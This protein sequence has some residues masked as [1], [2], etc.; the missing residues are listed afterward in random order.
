MTTHDLVLGGCR[1]EPLAA[2]LKALG[3]L[4]AVAEQ[5]DPDA[6]G[7]W[8][9][10]HFVLRSSL[11]RTALVEMFSTRWRP[12]PVV[13]PWNGGSGFYPKDN[14]EA[15][16]K[17]AASTDPRLA[18]YR[19][20]IAVAARE[21]ARNA[22]SERPVDDAKVRLLETMRSTLPDEGVSWVDAAVVVGDDRLLFPPL[23]G[24][25]GN[26]GRLDF[27]NNFMQRVV[28]VLLGGPDRIEATL[29]DDPIALKFQGAMGQFL[30]SASERTN[31]WDFVLLIEGALLFA[32]AATKKL[33]SAERGTMA[34]P[35]HARAALGAAT[36]SEKD[37]SGSR[38]ELWLPLW[39]R[40]ASLRELRA[41]L[42]E[43]RAKVGTRERGADATRGARDGLDFARAVAQ[44]G[45]DRGITAFSR[46][47]FHVRNG[48]AYY[49]TPLGRFET[50][51]VPE[52][53][54]FDALDPWIER[55]RRAARQ[56]GAPARVVSAARRLEDRMFDATTGDSFSRV[57]LALAD[58]EAAL[59]G[60]LAFTLEQRLRPLEALDAA[61]WSHVDW[62]QREAR[63]GVCLAQ[64]HELRRRMLPL[65][66]PWH[67][68]ARADVGTVFGARPL[69]ENL[70]ALLLREEIEEVDP[71]AST[72]RVSAASLSD[73]ASFIDGDVDDKLVEAWA[74]AASLIRPASPR[75]PGVLPPVRMPPASFA[76][77]ALVAGGSLSDETPLARTAG[78]VARGC[79]G[80]AR[81]STA[82]AI[83]RLK[84]AGRDVGVRPFLAETPAR[85]RRIAA[86][87]AFPL[88][89]TQRRSL[90]SMVL[91][92][93]AADASHEDGQENEHVDV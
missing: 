51:D 26:D 25:G 10:E 63:L 64:H 15:L 66:D 79:A 30:P 28:E 67:F 27:S 53:R 19:E 41:L 34:F 82:L 38:D 91:P 93:R 57:L 1:P 74:R 37:E 62:R 12:T 81:E 48:L 85:M 2:Y 39:Q 70:H 61:W 33:A 72:V 4:R 47:G 11:D 50:R 5:A 73:V 44:L 9:G 89:R 3:V 83:R 59:A 80:D 75:A 43:G 21:V 90:E 45:V 20:A 29:F 8:R 23:L 84:A 6:R 56:D 87:L 17:I 35:F 86:A 60:S 52:V 54:L 88:T 32:G 18:V 46:V 65:A 71:S 55:L 76:V 7:F 14:R 24:T 49:A 92:T 58:A 16:Q 36:L 42:G 40:P 68:A 77:L 69:L 13:A 78:M 22:W 31:P